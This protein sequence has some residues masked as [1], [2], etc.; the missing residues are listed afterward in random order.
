MEVRR[1]Q[2]IVVTVGMALGVGLLCSATAAAS[3]AW[4]IDALSN[5]TAAPGGTL[6]YLV[7]VTNVGGTDSDGGQLD[8]VATLPAGVKALSTASASADASFSCTG[9]GTI[10]RDRSCWVRSRC[11]TWCLRPTGWRDSASTSRGRS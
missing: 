4:R 8:L 9:P 10:F 5:T 2:G 1:L 6:D 11:S 3:P 7:Q